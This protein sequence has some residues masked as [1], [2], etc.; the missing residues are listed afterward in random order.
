M[1]A[2]KTLGHKFIQGLKMYSDPDKKKKDHKGPSIP[3]SLEPPTQTVL[4]TIL[5]KLTCLDEK[6]ED[7]E[8]K[9]VMLYQE[10]KSTNIRL[11]AILKL[12]S[13]PSAEASKSQD[14][15]DASEKETAFPS[16]ED[17]VK[18][19]QEMIDELLE[20]GYTEAEA[21][22]TV[23]P[24]EEVVQVPLACVTKEQW[25]LLKKRAVPKKRRQG[26]LP[27]YDVMEQPSS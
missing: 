4:Q 22:E 16:E 20:A 14:K 17:T 19:A 21:E 1:T 26:P 2:V 15:N 25:R 12:I 8:N 27:D 7:L 10:V 23:R 13:K 18:R 6:L 9:S 24:H 11:L 5:S 3:S